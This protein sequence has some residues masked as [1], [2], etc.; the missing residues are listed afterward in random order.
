MSLWRPRHSVGQDGPGWT[1]PSQ[2]CRFAEK[3][4]RNSDAHTETLF[5]PSFLLVVAL[6]G[7]RCPL[8]WPLGGFAPPRERVVPL[9]R[10][11]VPLELC[12]G[13]NRSAFVQ[14]RLLD[15][16]THILLLAEGKDADGD[17]GAPH[18]GLAAGALGEAEEAPDV[19][20][21]SVPVDSRRGGARRARREEG[22]WRH[23]QRVGL[24]T[25]LRGERSRCSSMLRRRGRAARPLSVSPSPSRLRSGMGGRRTLTGSVTATHRTRRRLARAYIREVRE[26]AR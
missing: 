14:R 4:G 10:G 20:T 25:G 3:V 6:G 15:G 5:S 18:E 13:P 8:R 9:C 7:G 26:Y 21:L 24:G 1:C 16:K 17:E 12:E 23:G 2:Q 11:P 22:E 19:F